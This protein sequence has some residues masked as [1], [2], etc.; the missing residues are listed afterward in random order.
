MAKWVGEARYWVH[1]VV[2]SPP[3]KAEVTV[4]MA[5][6]PRKHSLKKVTGVPCK[7]PHKLD[8]MILEALGKGAGF[9]V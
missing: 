8:P 1:E 4:N 2:K 9:Q 7:E 6:Q 5:G 3:N